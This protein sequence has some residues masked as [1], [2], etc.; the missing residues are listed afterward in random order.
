MRQIL[1]IREFTAKARLKQIRKKDEEIDKSN[2]TYV[3][4]YFRSHFE[5]EIYIFKF[6]TSTFNFMLMFVEARQ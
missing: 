2:A 3:L 5:K 6:S 4:K 1:L